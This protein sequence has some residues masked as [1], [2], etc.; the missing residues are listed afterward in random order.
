MQQ[1]KDR[2]LNVKDVLSVT[3][4]ELDKLLQ[5]LHRVFQF[6]MHRTAQRHN[7]AAQPSA[8]QRSPMPQQGHQVQPAP[9]PNMLNAANLQQLAEAEQRARRE[10]RERQQGRPPA[11][12][13]SL[14]PP[15]PIGASSPQGV[16]QAYGHSELTQDKLKFP[17]QKKRKQTQPGSTASTP[18]GGQGTPGPTSSPQV[19]KQP[20][21][22]IAKPGGKETAEP[23][24]KCQDPNCSFSKTGLKTQN[25]LAKH[26]TAAHRP[27]EP[28]INDPLGFATE[29]LAQ[30][31]G[32]DKDGHSK[33]IDEAAAQG[34]AKKSSEEKA[35]APDGAVTPSEPSKSSNLKTRFSQQPASS[36]EL[37]AVAREAAIKPVHDDDM[38]EDWIDFGEDDLDGEAWATSSVS[39]E[40][41]QRALHGLADPSMTCDYEVMKE[42]F[43]EARQTSD[44]E[45]SD[46]ESTSNSDVSRNDQ[47]EI[48][49]GMEA[50]PWIDVDLPERVQTLALSTRSRDADWEDVDLTQS[51]DSVAEKFG[52]YTA[53]DLETIEKDQ[54]A[55]RRME[56]KKYRLLGAPVPLEDSGDISARFYWHSKAFNLDLKDSS[57][58]VY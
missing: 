16:P 58:K 11:A 10:S 12:P 26:V 21:P 13:T 48:D 34:T 42:S 5:N 8:Q 28:P 56:K 33:V 30:Y 15:F 47:L 22:D 57:W 20:A 23:A 35:K 18:V 36:Q 46:K 25:D 9:A 38:M 32:L 39:F 2:E 29:N 43:L 44:A 24:F 40:G 55:S 37:N 45:S 1:Y 17:P 4:D 31:L 52:A 6:I 3:P 54:A 49:V 27:Q 14:Q 50:E 41:L 19:S 53:K 7:Q 51:F